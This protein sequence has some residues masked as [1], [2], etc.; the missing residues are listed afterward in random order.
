MVLS[1]RRVAAAAVGLLAR[2]PRVGLRSCVVSLSRRAA[3][4]SMGFVSPC[5]RPWSVKS[6]KG[7]VL[8]LCQVAL[9]SIGYG[10]QDL[11]RKI[12]GGI[13]GFST[14]FG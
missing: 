12:S 11:G 4:A 1:A 3:V 14:Q 10:S 6:G 9:G 2:P 5:F 13:P 7:W 8:E